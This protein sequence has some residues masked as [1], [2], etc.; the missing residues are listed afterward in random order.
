[1]D[2]KHAEASKTTLI[3][4]LQVARIKRAVVSIFQVS[5]C[6]AF[7]TLFCG[8]PYALAAP[9]G[10]NIVGGSGSINSAGLTTNINQ[11]SSSMVINWQS[12]NINANEVVNYLQPSASSTSLNLILGNNASQIHGPNK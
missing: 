9:A 7:L 11:L 6:S 8:M 5:A 10:G 1:M 3:F 4:S 12:Y 2:V